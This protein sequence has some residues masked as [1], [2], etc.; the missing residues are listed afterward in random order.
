LKR[1]FQGRRHLVSTPAHLILS[2]LFNKNNNNDNNDNNDNDRE[3]MRSLDASLNTHTETERER[4]SFDHTIGDLT[5]SADAFKISS[6]DNL[7]IGAM[8]TSICTS[9][10]TACSGLSVC[11]VTEKYPIT[12]LPHPCINI[13]TEQPPNAHPRLQQWI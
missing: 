1:R 4:E 10:A 3:E 5:T 7:L 11:P 9:Q 6:F 8:I 12:K 13:R 2:F